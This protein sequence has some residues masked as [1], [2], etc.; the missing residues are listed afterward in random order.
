M[1]QHWPE[2]HSTDAR[3]VNRTQYIR[4]IGL[5]MPYRKASW[6]RTQNLRREH[7]QL[8]R[9]AALVH[10]VYPALAHLELKFVNP[11]PQLFHKRC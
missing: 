6:D 3:G 8:Y 4:S 9:V 11:W 2:S 5:T 7:L 1:C 10:E